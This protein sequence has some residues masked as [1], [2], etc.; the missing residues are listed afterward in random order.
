MRTMILTAYEGN[1]LT[2]GVPSARLLS[3]I[4][5]KKS[6]TDNK[7]STYFLTTESIPE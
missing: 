2:S 5:V 7:V 3:P 1:R 4:I 6:L